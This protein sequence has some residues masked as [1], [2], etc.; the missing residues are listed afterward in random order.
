MKAGF[1]LKEIRGHLSLSQQSFAD[2]LDITRSNLSHIESGRVGASLEIINHLATKFNI[3]VNVFI[4]CLNLE[5][6]LLPKLL[7]KLLPND[8]NGNLKGNPNGN[9]SEKTGAF[10]E[11]DVDYLPRLVTVDTAGEDAISIVNTKAAAGY[12]NGYGDPEYLQI[13]PTISAPG[14]RGALHR[15]FEVKGNSMPP[16]HDGSLAICRYVERL[17]D[18]RNRYVYVI[19]SRNDGIVL[20][21]VINI[22]DEHKLILISDN[23]NKREFPNYSIDYNDIIE[24]WLWRGAV[25]RSIP[26]PSDFYNRM[27][28]MEARMTI[29][30]EYMQQMRGKLK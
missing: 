14:F 11:A 17:A 20:K 29:M 25:I 12:L 9:L 19:V 28:E 2:A 24:I 8:K 26:D 7:P 16:N 1:I 5:E 13:L 21:R 6:S 15:C 30:D 18:I 10:R 27:N 23:P 4:E 22:P 3:D